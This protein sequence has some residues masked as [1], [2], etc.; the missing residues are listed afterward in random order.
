MRTKQVPIAEVFTKYE[1]ALQKGGWSYATRYDFLKRA[2]VIVHLHEQRGLE[3]ID[4]KIIADYADGIT[5][6]FYKGEVSKHYYQGLHRGIRRFAAFAET[7]EVKL[8]N[9]SKGSRQAL[10]PVFEQIAEGYLSTPMHPNTRNDARWVAHRY[11]AWLAEQGYEDLNG[12]G[13]EQIQRFLL[14]SSGKMSMNSIH[15]VKLYI[16]KLYAYLYETGQSDSS[17]HALLSFTVNR[18]S[19]IYPALPKADIAKILE[20]IDRKTI[21]G[22]RAYAVMLLGAVLGLRACDVANLKLMDIDWV[23]GE[24]KIL[25]SKT[26]ETV[27][28]PLTK[29]VGEALQDYILNA[30]PKTEAKH[31]FIRLD[32]PFTPIKAAVTIGE[33]FRDC[34][35]AAGINYGKRFHALRRSLGTSMVNAGT[36]VTTVAQVLGHTEIDSTKK[37]IAVDTEHLKLCALPF[38]SIIPIGG[39]AR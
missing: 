14:D 13:A 1:E 38:D 27:V 28:L 5:G 37:Y 18:G 11:F 9:P 22:K 24:I 17:Y 15:N 26:A 19:K 6:R 29:D 23:N 4:Q 35:N 12:V 34:C 20:A 39:R 36:P 2:T 16:S 8:P 25:Q 21:C 7:G 30:R 31:I 33:I 10:T 3:H 32:A